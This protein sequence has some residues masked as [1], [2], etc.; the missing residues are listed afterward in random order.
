MRSILY[1]ETLFSLLQNQV[2]S[3]RMKND[4]G[5]FQELAEV[6][7]VSKTQLIRIFHGKHKN[8]KYFRVENSKENYR[9]HIINNCVNS[10]K[11]FS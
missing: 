3:L 9:R 6:V 4:W 1:T 10:G 5:T 2:K 7:G 8:Q 11:T